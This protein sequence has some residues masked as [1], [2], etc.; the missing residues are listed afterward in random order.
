MP[1]HRLFLPLLAALLLL[2]CKGSTPSPASPPS[3][4]TPTP[5]LQTDSFK[6]ALTTPSG[7]C[8]VF[9][10]YPVS[11]SPTLVGALRDFIKTTLFDDQS[12]TAPDDPAEL[13]RAYVNRRQQSLSHSLNQMGVAAVDKRDAPEEGVDIRLVCTAPQFVTYEVYR[14]SYITH[15]AHG[16]YS[17]YGVTFRRS[18]GRRM[19]HILNKVDEGLYQHIRHGLKSYFQVSSDQALADICTV[20][21]SLMPMPTFPPYLVADGVRFHYSIYDICTFDDGDPSFTIPYALALP[22][23]TDEARA[24]VTSPSRRNTT[25]P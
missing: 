20:D 15:G 14:Y 18:D 5:V 24:L 22:Y 8:E 10:D 12:S 3:S 19:T 17:D 16:E 7:R 1:I 6:Y 9:V 4:P 2:G 21:L 11:G 23:M 25:K 13:V